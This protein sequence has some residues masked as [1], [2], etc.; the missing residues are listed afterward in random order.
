MII[1]PSSFIVKHRD[2]YIKDKLKLYL[3]VVPCASYLST[4]DLEAIGLGVQGQH[5]IHCKVEPM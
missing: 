1:H 4:Y 5:Q 3:G 2:V